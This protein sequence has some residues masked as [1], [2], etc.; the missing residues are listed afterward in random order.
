M[1]RQQGERGTKETERGQHRDSRG[2]TVVF[3]TSSQEGEGWK[4]RQRTTSRSLFQA[5]GSDMQ[6]ASRFLPPKSSFFYFTF[7]QTK[8]AN[9]VCSGMA[10]PGFWRWFPVS[11]GG[12]THSHH[13]LTQ[14]FYLFQSNISQH[15]SHPVSFPSA[16]SCPAVYLNVCDIT[17]ATNIRPQSQRG[18][19][20]Q[21]ESGRGSAHSFSFFRRPAGHRW[22]LLHA[23]SKCSSHEIHEVKLNTDRK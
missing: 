6:L 21:S 13:W 7:L 9:Q 20:R 5:R 1:L 11:R 8:P 4:R 12:A 15:A 18:D 14:F 19:W 10:S 16:E 23:Q 22:R 2:E 17:M 3:L